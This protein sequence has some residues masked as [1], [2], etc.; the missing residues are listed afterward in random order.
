MSKASPP[1]LCGASLTA[2]PIS[3]SL[4]TP[5]SR[6]SV[7]RH[8]CAMPASLTIHRAVTLKPSDR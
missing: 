5:A 2:M 4:A 8:R 6:S 3:L 7:A 1:T